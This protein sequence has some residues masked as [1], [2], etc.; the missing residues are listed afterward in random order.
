M[1]RKLP[2][3]ILAPFLLLGG[4]DAFFSN[5]FEGLYTLDVPS[6]AELLTLPLSDME[7]L[8]EDPQ[9]FDAL[10]A[11]SE[12]LDVVK[13]NLSGQ[14]DATADTPEEQ[15]AAALYAE[16]VLRTSGAD[17]I[18]AGLAGYL[19]SADGFD[20]FELD[21]GAALADLF[22]ESFPTL[23]EIEAMVAALN[24]AWNAYAAIGAGLDT[25]P[26]DDSLNAGDL[27]FNAALAA[28]LQGVSVTTGTVAEMIYDA[29]R[30]LDISGYGVE[31]FNNTILTG[32]AM[33]N[34]LSAAGFDPEQF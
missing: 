5:V 23:E 21:P 18:V 13:M 3:L 33:G 24:S 1:K 7:R 25:A 15:R 14:Y 6:S 30:G 29:S 11:D 2:A 27:A 34:L 8:A 17:R 19:A 12:K 20:Q 32:T 10:S 26:L 31:P 4:C 9:F 22:G 28:A 16:V